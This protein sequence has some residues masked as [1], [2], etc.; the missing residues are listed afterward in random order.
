MTQKKKFVF[1]NRL[2]KELPPHDP[3]GGG[4]KSSEYSDATVTGLRAVVGK[5]GNKSF[6]FRYQLSGGRKRCAR[7][8]T[9]PAIDVAEARRIALEMRAVVDRGGDPL[10]QHDRQKTMP[11]FAEFW[12]HEYAP[13]AMQA[14]KS[15][16]NDESKVRLHLKP[17]FGSRRLCEIG[18]RDVQL[19]HAAMRVSHTAA[20][21]NRH[22]ALLSAIFRKAV[23]WGRVDKNP[24]AGIKPFK[25][26]NQHQRF[27]TNDEIA[28]I[29]RAMETEPNKTAVAALKLLLLTGA[30]REE[31]LQ[32]RWEHVDL[33]VG[34]WW[35]PMTKSGRGRYVALSD[36]AK[37]LL[38][39]QPSRGR[40]P[41]V[42]P[43]RDEDKPLN[44]PRKAFCRILAAAGVEHLR[45]HDLRHSFASLAVNAGA[46]LYEVQGLLGHSSAQMTQRYAHLADSGLRRASQAVADVVAAAV[47]NDIEGEWSTMTEA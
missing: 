47:R 45:I 18:V 42:F 19:H 10:E 41:W 14:K 34:Q 4:S 11:T 15:F 29:F 40:S 46:T 2:I 36:G 5:N 27:L 21:A 8:G 3:N 33:E 23:E 9:F 16:R 32:A 25:E 13:Y 7:I 17:R 39:S 26:A 38:A 24:A 1:T 31:A 37:E 30:R 43:G 12:D 22:L 44:N 28:R 20:T 6:S 35:L